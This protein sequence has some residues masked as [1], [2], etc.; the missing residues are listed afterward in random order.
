[1]QREV[2]AEIVRLLERGERFAVA[3]LVDAHG[4]TPQRVGARLLVRADG[5]TIGTLG[6][7]CI[8]AE[9][10]EQAR[11]AIESGRAATLDFTLNED[12]AVD[13]GLACGGTER[14]FIDPS[15]GRDDA[16]LTQAMVRATTGSGSGAVVT[17]IGPASQALG[18]KVGVWD[19]GRVTGNMGALQAEAVASARE[20]MNAAR[21]R[22][23]MITLEGGVEAF[24]DVFAE[25]AEVVI[26]GGG[27]VGR[28]VATIA[29]TLGY[30]I[31]VIDDR[32]DFA[33]RERFPEAETVLAGDIEESIDNYAMTRNSAVIIVTRGHK[34]DYQA[35]SAAARSNA[36]Y[37]GL[38]GSRRKVMLIY[39]QLVSDGTPPER[40]RDIHAPIGLDIGAV[41]PEEIAVSIMAEVTMHRLG[42]S[43]GSMRDE[44]LVERARP[45]TVA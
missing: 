7:G 45:S 15:Y 18:S 30:R 5:S 4:S 23:A 40:L 20:I 12:I 28:A 25:P 35:L 43:G 26:I 32:E 17:I 27:H 1:M 21:P 44:R 38:M 9:V 11:A 31:A 14:I 37:V 34:Y 19:D 33:S 36:G 42:G 41:S 16:A 13:Y 24:A 3:T 29:H 22:P 39:R 10:W 6:G 8:E 2:T